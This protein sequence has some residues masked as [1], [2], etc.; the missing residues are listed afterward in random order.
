M[1]LAYELPVIASEAG[2][3]RDLF[4]KFRIGVTFGNATPEAL[5][6]AIRALYAR[7]SHSDL[8]E[9]IKAAKSEFSWR[10]AAR[11]TIAGYSLAEQKV[12][13]AHACPIPATATN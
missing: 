1:A 7:G 12:T 8:L 9:Q 11:A 3:L 6:A 13:D 10:E 2:G 4:D 5:A